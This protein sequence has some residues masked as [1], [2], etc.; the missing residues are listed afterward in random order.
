MGQDKLSQKEQPMSPVL[1][2]LVIPVYNEFEG[3]P[4]LHERLTKLID[5]FAPDHAEVIFVNDG[6]KDGSDK[7]LDAVA[8]KDPRF[9]VI[10]FSRNF[11]H[12]LAITAGIEWASGQTVTVMDADLQDPPELVRELIAKWREGFE[13]VYAVRRKRDGETVFKLWTAKLFY[14]MIRKMTHVDIP[15]DTGDFRLMDR[16]AVDAL[17]Q[18]PERHRFV[19]GMVSWV[20]FRQTGVLYDRAERTFGETHYPFKK[21]LKFALDGVTSFSTVPLQFGT[22]L[23]MGSA[24]LALLLAIKIVYGWYFHNDTVAGWTSLMLVVLLMGAMQLFTLGIF[25]EYLGRTYEEVKG[26]PLYLVGRAVG[27]SRDK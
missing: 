5:S 12:Q 22:Y 2:S 14:R 23:G 27:F 24:T 7:A 18:M 25:G 21:M 16:K 9:K 4:S 11:G 20:G 8:A 19:R 13:V 1:H 15:V 3:I 17:I 26:R 6:S 10:H